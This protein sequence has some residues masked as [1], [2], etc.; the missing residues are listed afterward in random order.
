MNLGFNLRR[1]SIYF[2]E[3]DAIVFG[4]SSFSYRDI[5]RL[6]NRFGNIL[7]SIGVKK[8]DKVC[9]YL[10]N[11][12]EFII[13]FFG[14]VKI[15]AI[16]VS[17]SSLW[18]RDEV[19]YV[20]EDSE[21][22]TLVTTEELIQ[23]IPELDI[24]ERLRNIII[25]GEKCD[26]GIS[27][28]EMM[29]KSHDELSIM[30]ME[31]D[32]VASIIYTSGT[33]GKPKGAML[34]HGNVI[35]NSFS[36]IHHTLMKPEDILICF[37]PL[38]HSFGQ[39][40]IMNS[41]I[42]RGATLILHKKFELDEIVNSIKSNRVTR[43]FGVPTIYIM[44]LN[45][46]KTYPFLKS[47]G[48]CFS[49]AASMPAEVSKKWKETFGLTIYEGYGLTE[50]TPF[51]SYNHD[52]K[53]RS[54]SIGTPIENV[55]MKVV[56]ENGV[57]LPP[58]QLGEIVIKGPNVMKG[59]YNKPEETEKTIRNGWLHSGDIGMTDDDGYF[60]I[61]DRVKDMINSAGFKIWPREVE[62]VL[63][64][65]PAVLECAVIGVPDKV[66][67]ERVKAFIILREG[68][69]ASAEEI[70]A[71]CKERIASYKAP[72]EIEFV[73]EI[74]KSP[75]GKILKRILREAERSKVKEE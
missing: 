72:K 42:C 32:D 63:F 10:P 12:P 37:L 59:Y 51:A 53:Y 71:F 19:S 58:G 66:Y 55:E 43:F 33:T 16:A 14:I 13:C 75:T 9:I 21:A 30:E 23:N 24:S 44:L 29:E 35:S 31:K 61:V 38:Y 62:E 48:Y 52:I 60:Y 17:I 15:G 7:K 28:K 50:T 39:N 27:Y 25:I 47:L 20:I 45:E 49:A 67:G 3:K 1:S 5:E 2:P 46:E 4:R 34:T 26:K 69:R 68:E 57:Q 11:I 65:H 64:K 8:G 74:P 22:N 36:A 54:G 40:F 56:D 6:S 70:I 18:K 41:C 73:K